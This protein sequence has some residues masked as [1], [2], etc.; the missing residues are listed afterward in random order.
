MENG[1][2]F[3]GRKTRE[4]ESERGGR[5]EKKEKREKEAFFFLFFLRVVSLC[6]PRDVPPSLSFFSI[7]SSIFVALEKFPLCSMSL[8]IYPELAT[9]SCASPRRKEITLDAASCR[10]G[11]GK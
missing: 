11:R 9:Q 5:E 3:F 4:Q 10:C 7:F 2:Q 8:E 6:F 1:F